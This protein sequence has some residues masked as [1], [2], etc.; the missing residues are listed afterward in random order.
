MSEKEKIIR[1]PIVYQFVMIALT[2]F[3]IYLFY[4][5]NVQTKLYCAAMFFILLNGWASSIDNEFEYGSLYL[6]VDALCSVMYFLALL[7]IKDGA[8]QIV[9]LLSSIIVALYIIWNV[10]LQL[11]NKYDE[12]KRKELISYN[13]SNFILLMFSLFTFL[14]LIFV[15]NKQVQSISQIIGG[16]I[17]LM[18]LLKWYY[19]NYFND[20]KKM[21]KK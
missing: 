13:W 6:L 11:F 19:D 8:F 21:N 9:W 14:I 18:L 1:Y 16:I 4:S 5:S 17:W 2:A 15:E 3:D 10:L 7:Y 20:L 12:N